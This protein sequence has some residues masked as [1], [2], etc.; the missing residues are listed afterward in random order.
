MTV[1]SARHPEPTG[2]PDTDETELVS[3]VLATLLREDVV[4]LRT[5][6]TRLTREDGDWVRLAGT[7]AFGPDALLL[8]VQPDGFLCADS[9]REPL[10]LRESDG[11][12]LRTIADVL[13]ALTA[14]ADHTDHTGFAA[15]AEECGQA[16][17][18]MRLHRKTGSWVSARLIAHYGRQLDDWTGGAG[19]AFDTLAARL[20]HPVHPAGRARSG[21]SANQLRCYAP[22]FHPRFRLRWLAVPRTALIIAG[23][24]EFPEYWPTP[25]RVGLRRLAD[26]HV[27]LPVHPLTVGAT[28]DLALRESGLSDECVLL[29]RP[30]LEVVPTLSMRTVASAGDPAQHLKLPLATATLGQRNLRTIRPRT[31]ADGALCQQ[32]LIAVITREERFQTM[33]LLADEST[34]AHA[35]HELLAVLC[36]RYPAA[37]D[38]AVVVPMAALLSEAPDGRRVLDHLADRF[39]SGD[40]VALFDAWIRLLF[41]WQITLFGYGIALEA[42]QQNISLVLDIVP[43]AA[44]AMTRLRLLFKDNDTPRVNTARLQARIG[45]E[46]ATFIDPRINVTDD[47][48]LTDL[49][50]TI[51]MHLCAGWYAFELARLGYAPLSQLLGQVRDRLEEAISRIDLVAGARLRA[52]LLDAPTLPVKAMVSAGTLLSKQRSGAADINKHYT[53]GPNY[54]RHL[55]S[56]Q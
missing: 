27:L 28:L 47:Q 9:V 51:T 43:S 5:H 20:D 29:D 45:A 24:S 8:P 52:A 11:R 36:R 10:V 39:Y 49:F 54:L 17:A 1:T 56:Y 25:G 26:S 50:I 23:R 13:T 30:Y 31:L 16:L 2:Y 41:D 53:S 37:L 40:P 35:G 32:L 46:P 42:H 14:F 12:Q 33:I 7:T 6:A 19:L 18:T 34:Y 38:G 3:R 48:P 44:G 4:G 15:F 22:E 55:G 21:L